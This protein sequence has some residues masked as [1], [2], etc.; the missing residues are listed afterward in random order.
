MAVRKRAKTTKG[1]RKTAKTTKRKTKT[2]KVKTT[3]KK[4][5][6]KTKAKAKKRGAPKNSGFMKPLTP[7]KVLSAIVGGKALPRT[8]VVK[9]LWVYIK[10][11]NLQ[12][13]LN[14]RMINADANLKAV[15]GGKGKVNMFQMTKLIS[16][17]LK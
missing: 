14:R 7:S 3:K 4:A 16:K 12:D 1:K 10:K 8:Q 17:H 11:H 13:K 9:K 15:F 5:K 6:T 2:K